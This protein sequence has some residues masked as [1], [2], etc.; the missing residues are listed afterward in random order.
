MCIGVQVS[1]DYFSNDTFR[2]RSLMSCAMNERNKRIF[3][4]EQRNSQSLFNGIEENLKLQLLSL[5]VKKSLAVKRVCDPDEF[6]QLMAFYLLIRSVWVK[7]NA[8]AMV[9][10][11]KLYNIAIGGLV[12]QGIN[13]KSSNSISHDNDST[14]SARMDQLQNQLNQMM[15]MMQNN[16]DMPGVQSFNATD[17]SLLTYKKGT[18]FMA[19]I[20]YVDDIL[21]TGNNN[22]LITHFKKEL[23]SAFSIKDI[24]QLNYYLGIE[25]LRNSKG[26]TMSQRKYALELL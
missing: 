7:R 23:D 21:L 2:G 24:G 11:L 4:Q 1:Q 25:F 19:L 14:M 9:D 8:I 20:I 3:S 6:Y 12:A 18:D 22:T 10:V 13:A 15:L 5:K 26:I 16:K 17:I